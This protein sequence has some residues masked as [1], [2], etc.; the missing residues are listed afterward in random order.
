MMLVE[1]ALDTSCIECERLDYPGEHQLEFGCV[2]LW[3]VGFFS[4]I[5]TYTD[6]ANRCCLL[7]RFVSVPQCI[8]CY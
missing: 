7:N 2:N 3:S 6:G 4:L 1:H 8:Y 5:Q